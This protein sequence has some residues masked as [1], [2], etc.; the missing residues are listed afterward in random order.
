M[1][2]NINVLRKILD[3]SP[4]VATY[5]WASLLARTFLCAVLAGTDTAQVARQHMASRRHMHVARG[6]ITTV[7]ACGSR[8]VY[9]R[10]V[11]NPP[12][13]SVGYNVAD[14]IRTT[15]PFANA[16]PSTWACLRDATFQ[17]PLRCI[18]PRRARAPYVIEQRVP[19]DEKQWAHVEGTL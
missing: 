4:A 18:A 13:K 1:N 9:V 16:Q 2:N 19:T 8:D 3:N 14:Y 17:K 6:V 15:T 5:M 7:A 11:S 12:S 10:E